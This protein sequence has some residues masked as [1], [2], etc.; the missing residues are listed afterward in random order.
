MASTLELLRRL[1]TQKV[2]FVLVG[3]M[4]AIAHGSAAVTED[5]DVC[6]RFDEAT[7]SGIFRALAGTNPRQRMHPARPPLGDEPR[8]FVGNKNLYV[9]TDEGVIDLLGEIVAVGGYDAVAAT[10]LSLDLGGFQCRV[11]GLKE[12]IACKRALGRPK[13]LRVAQELEEVLSRT[14]GR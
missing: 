9:V 13:D 1:S 10:A 11:V 8:A 7:L 12:L 3:G 14:G 4:A 6:I 5:V 2:D